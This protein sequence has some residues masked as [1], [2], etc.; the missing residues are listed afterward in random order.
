MYPAMPYGNDDGRRGQAM[1]ARGPGEDF[2]QVIDTLNPHR[3]TRRDGLSLRRFE[4]FTMQTRQQPDWRSNADKCADYY[5]HNQ[6]T[7]ERLRELRNRGMP[8]LTKNLIKP[9]IDLILGIE[10]QNKRDWR[11]EGDNDDWQETAEGLSALL[12]QSERESRADQAISD[13]FAGQ[14]KSGLGWIEV[15]PQQDPFRWYMTVGTVHR[16]EMWW[17]WFAREPDLSDGEFLIRR[18]WYPIAYLQAVWPEWRG[19]FANARDNWGRWW[20]QAEEQQPYLVEAS[21]QAA[22]TSLSEMEWID[23]TRNRICLYEVMYKVWVRGMVCRLPD[24]TVI[25]CDLDDPA[26]VAAINAGEYVPEPAVYSRW[27]ESLWAGPFRLADSGKVPNRLRYIPFWGFREDLTGVPYGIIRGMVSQQDEVN[28]RRQMLMWLLSAKRIEMDSDALDTKANTVEEMLDI[29]NQPDAAILLNPQ[30]RNARFKVTSDLGLAAQQFDILQDAQQGL[31][32]V[33]GVYKQ[34]LGDGGGVTAGIAINQ[35][36]NQG[37]VG[38]AK[39]FDNYGYA[40]RLVGERKLD[41]IRDRIQGKR[42]EVVV[43][44]YGGKRTIIVL[45]DPQVH[46]ETGE[47]VLVNN[48]AASKVKVALEDTPSTPT[49]RQQLMTTLGEVLKSLPPEMQALLVPY[50]LELSDVPKRHEMAKL[51]RKQLGLLGEDE[52]EADPE[53]AEL[54]AKLEQALALIEQLQKAPEAKLKEA[55]ALKTQAEAAKLEQEARIEAEK[56]QRETEKIAAEA[57]LARANT[58]KVVAET[59]NI[60]HPPE[61]EPGESAVHEQGETQTQETAE[62]TAGGEDDEAEW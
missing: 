43:G 61:P 46:P 51:I 59:V 22:R 39:M 5:D 27:R 21:D 45:N 11:V 36:I 3:D 44:E 10:A 19:V 9:T 31:Q 54:K 56:G 62:H 50:Y 52:E 49:Y 47:T 18:R 28:A 8:P 4:E 16:R 1:P 25:E 55:Q 53:K 6:I 42:T 23:R 13:A 38:L 37:T 17:D 24:D 41:L 60:I 14:I 33:A 12:H 2:G 30:A 15:A 48:T 29:I 34:M 58:Q 26:Q 35:L 20:M 7:P 40:R 57:A 32:D